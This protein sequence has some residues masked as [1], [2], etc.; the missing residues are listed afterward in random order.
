MAAIKVE[1]MEVDLVHEGDGDFTVVIEG[2]HAIVEIPLE[3]HPDGT[4]EIFRT[5]VW[6]GSE[7]EGGGR[8][9]FVGNEEP[10][11]NP[12]RSILDLKD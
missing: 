12:R 6:M 2:S 3:L 5:K 10:E 1:N 9:W 11:P 7:T 4:V 8:K